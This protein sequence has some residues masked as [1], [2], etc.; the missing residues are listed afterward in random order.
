M[1]EIKFQVFT[2]DWEGVTGCFEGYFLQLLDNGKYKVAFINSDNDKEFITTERENI[3]LFTGLKD[4]K[5]KEIYEGDIIHSLSPFF[6]GEGT[7]HDYDDDYYKVVWKDTGFL[8]ETKDGLFAYMDELIEPR[9]IG[10]I[11]ENPELLEEQ[12]G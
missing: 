5:C 12:H 11:Y 3:R 10:N 2:T 6:T 8:L 1:R 9:V 4:K 7:I